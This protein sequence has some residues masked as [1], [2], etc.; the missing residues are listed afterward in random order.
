[1]QLMAT[2]LQKFYYKNIL[3]VF[4]IQQKFVSL[5][6]IFYYGILGKTV[7]DAA[8]LKTCTNMH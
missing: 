4:L 7:I 2:V 5:K 6:D 3:E 8:F 1:M